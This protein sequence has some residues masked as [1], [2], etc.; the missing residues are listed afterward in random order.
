MVLDRVAGA[1][2]A[3]DEEEVDALAVDAAI[4]V[5]VVRGDELANRDLRHHLPSGVARDDHLVELA[6]QAGFGLIEQRALLE[7]SVHDQAQLVGGIARLAFGRALEWD[8]VELPEPAFAVRTVLPAATLVP[9]GAPLGAVPLFAQ[10]LNGH[11]ADRAHGEDQGN[12]QRVSIKATI[13]GG[14]APV[15]RVAWPGHFIRKRHFV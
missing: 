3:V 13:S 10:A 1:A 2:V 9:I 5:R 14:M 4:G 15:P 7:R 12:Q 11:A 8:G 6:K